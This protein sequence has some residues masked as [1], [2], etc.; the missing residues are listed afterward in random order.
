MDLYQIILTII[1][2]VLFIVFICWIGDISDFLEKKKLKKKALKIRVTKLHKK[3]KK[4][5][6]SHI[7]LVINT[8]KYREKQYHISDVI[9]EE[10][11][12]NP[13]DKNIIERLVSEIMKY[14]YDTPVIIDLELIVGNESKYS[15]KGAVGQYETYE[16]H[17]KI[18]LLLKPDHTP[19]EIIGIVCHECMHDYLLSNM[20]RIEPEKENEVFTD[21]AAIYL[22]FWVYIQNAYRER[23]RIKSEKGYGSSYTIESEGTK[24]GYINSVQIEYVIKKINDF[25]KKYRRKAKKLDKQKQHELL[26][27]ERQVKQQKMECDAVK[28]LFGELCVCYSKNTELMDIRNIRLDRELSQK[29]LTA[30]QENFYLYESEELELKIK[31][32][33]KDVQ[34]LTIAT[35]NSDIYRIKKEISELKEKIITWNKLLS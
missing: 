16:Y 26:N 13:F 23:R 30:I 19:H 32:I 9:W 14:L 31:S 4:Y 24:I 20:I 6:D 12:I 22:G 35:S 33:K 27:Q 1:I 17:R 34:K 7:E 18:R 21:I 8:L 3:D 5:L 15:S 2:F 28:H 29:D 10:L 11:A 25:R